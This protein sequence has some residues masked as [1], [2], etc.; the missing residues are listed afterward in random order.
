MNFTKLKYLE[1]LKVE[2]FDRLKHKGFGRLIWNFLMFPFTSN[3]NYFIYLKWKKV[4]SSISNLII[5]KYSNVEI[6]AIQQNLLSLKKGLKNYGERRLIINTNRA[7]I[8]QTK[9]HLFIFPFNKPDN[10]NGFY[11]EFD[12]PFKIKFDSKNEEY[13]YV[14][15][16]TV[17]SINKIETNDFKT[18]IDFMSPVF[19]E[20]IKL[21]IEKK[22]TIAN[23]V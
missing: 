11:T 13:K 18:I 14:D 1:F 10:I 9:N 23:N 12:F 19:E 4:Q 5:N 8:I 2:Y 22:I 15:I 16:P 6:H 17:T 3:M 20:N 7:D 21:T